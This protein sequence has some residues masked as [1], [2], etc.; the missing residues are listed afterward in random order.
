MPVSSGLALI[1]L[2]FAVLNSR[3][4]LHLFPWTFPLPSFAF[5]DSSHSQHRIAF[6]HVLYLV[7]FLRL[8][9]TVQSKWALSILPDDW[10]SWE[11][12]CSSTMWM[13]TVSWTS[14]PYRLGKARERMQVHAITRFWTSTYR[15]VLS[16]VVP[17]EDSHQSEYIA[18]CD[19][20]RGEYSLTTLNPHLP[21][22]HVCFQLLSP[23]LRAPQALPLFPFP[24]PH[25]RPMDV[26][27]IK[28]LNSWTITGHSWNAE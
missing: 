4:L 12:W 18:P 8:C 15:S 9:F 11:S 20:R 14:T 21:T 26:T 27:S 7:H 1:T 25:S 28:Q 6:S 13:Y 5:R 16:I 24:R 17:S 2:S 19:A 22:D 3:Y 10:S 23:D